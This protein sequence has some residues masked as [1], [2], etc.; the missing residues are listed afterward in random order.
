MVYYNKMIYNNNQLI[1]KLIVKIIE[2]NKD[3]QYNNIYCSILHKNIYKYYLNII[4]LKKKKMKC[5]Y[6]HMVNQIYK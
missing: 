1:L 6:T 4:D 2:E 3:L 5:I